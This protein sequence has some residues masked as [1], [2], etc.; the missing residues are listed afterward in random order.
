MADGCR[1]PAK[2]RPGGRWNGAISAGSAESRW[3]E[4]D[5]MQTRSDRHRRHYDT[6][7]K[8]AHVSG[9]HES[10]VTLHPMASSRMR[11]MRK[12]VHLNEGCFS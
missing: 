4:R 9:K 10:N 3:G 2:T 1:K 5:G 7:W 11:H 8:K 12:P 6:D